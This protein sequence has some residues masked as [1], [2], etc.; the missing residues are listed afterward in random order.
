MDLLHVYTE[1]HAS[2]W[3]RGGAA[4][5]NYSHPVT[6]PPGPEPELTLM[7]LGPFNFKKGDIVELYF[8]FQCSFPSQPAHP[9]HP[10]DLG[11]IGVGRGCF[12]KPSS[13]TENP[14]P[15]IVVIPGTM[16][17][18]GYQTGNFIMTH[19]GAEEFTDDADNQYY[20]VW[21]VTEGYNGG[22]QPAGLVLTIPKAGVSFYFKHYG[23]P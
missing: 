10:L 12:R 14:N 8:Q 21:I 23:T 7:R 18:V 6:V 2:F 16:A 9:G 4:T 11:D 15:S 20:H 5:G 17:N 13:N 22:P 19:A 1:T 3:W